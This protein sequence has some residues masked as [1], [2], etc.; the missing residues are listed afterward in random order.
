MASF[1]HDHSSD[2]MD[3]V[4]EAATTIR[5]RIVNQARFCPS[6][7]MCAKTF[8]TFVNVISL[9]SLLNYGA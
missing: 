6:N 5:R 1:I 7:A 8:Q 4:F 2:T 3:E 9:G